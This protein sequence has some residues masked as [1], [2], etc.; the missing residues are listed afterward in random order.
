MQQLVA[1]AC[2]TAAYSFSYIRDRP[3]CIN[4]QH[5]YLVDQEPIDHWYH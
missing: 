4:E 5:L 3:A 2:H 1:R